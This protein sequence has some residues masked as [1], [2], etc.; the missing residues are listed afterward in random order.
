MSYMIYNQCGLKIKGAD[1]KFHK[2]DGIMQI[3]KNIVKLTFE[4]STSMVVSR[5]HKFFINNEETFAENLKV[6]DKLDS[7][8][9]EHIVKTIDVTTTE[10]PVYSP[11]NVAPD[12][13]YVTPNGVVNGN[14]AF[15]GSTSTLVSPDFLEKMVPEDPVTY[16]FGYAFKIWE[17]PVKD[18]FY[19]MG[20]DS[21][22]GTGKD[23]AV[24]QVL[25]IYSKEHIEQVAVYMNNT[26]DAEHF[27]S[28]VADINRFYNDAPM[29]I[30]N[31]EIGKTVA[32]KVW[33]EEECGS[34]LNTDHNGKIGTRA[35]KTSKLDAC[36]ELKRLIENNIL[37]LKDAE[38]IKQ[39]SRFEEVKTNVFQ[40]PS[41]SHDDLVSG[42]Y[43]ACYCSM[44][45]QID[46]DALA[47]VKKKE[48]D[49]PPQT[50]F[51]ESDED[52]WGTMLL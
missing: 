6:G 26:I 37:T 39:L 16:K 33:Y 43:W 46:Y 51:F 1:G 44:Q 18:A 47:M 22:S 45:P 20:V 8:K 32:D 38:T 12:H 11:V 10:Q 50:T 30:E 21:S 15:I 17:L 5:G 40:G 7:I 34:I 4:D 9:G 13:K 23:Y 42:L 49:E 48:D 29:V 41:T 14:C 31:N 3:T 24:I 28:V 36:I 2:F 52:V 19:V 25:R 27:A 35:T